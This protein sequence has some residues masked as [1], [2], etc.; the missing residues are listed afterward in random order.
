MA[1]HK[2]NISKSQEDHKL[3]NRKLIDSRK[4]IFTI[5]GLLSLRLPGQWWWHSEDI[6]E[7]NAKGSIFRTWG[8]GDPS[9]LDIAYLLVVDV[10]DDPTEPDISVLTR[11]DVPSIDQFLQKGIAQ[12]LKENE[13]E[14]VKW[15]SSQLNETDS[16]KGLVT[17]YITLDQGKERQFIVLRLSIK[18]HK[19]VV[20]GCFDVEQRKIL[21]GPI[22]EALQNVK[23]LN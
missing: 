21:A 22:F 19:V 1:E 4:G 18:G 15:M 6:N 7:P 12:S 13:I 10:T 3:H 17:A 8:D 11:A 16:N 2:S 5:L 23:V 14:L 9:G 20:M